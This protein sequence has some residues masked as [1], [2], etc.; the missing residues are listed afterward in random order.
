[1]TEAELQRAVLGLCGQLD[2]RI[3]VVHLHDSRHATAD[4]RGLPDL[5]L[6]GAHRC[7]WRE[8]KPASGRP[9]GPQSQWLHWLREVGQDAGVWKPADWH[10]GTIATELAELNLSEGQAGAPVVSDDPDPEQAFFRVLY[11]LRGKADHP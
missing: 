5:F 11:G 10:D 1:M 6:I 7:C 4:T 2:P 3:R 8:L 9:R